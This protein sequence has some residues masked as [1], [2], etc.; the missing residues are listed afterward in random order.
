MTALRLF[1]RFG[2]VPMMIVGLN[3]LAVY[4][5][6][7]GYSFLWICFLFGVAVALSLLTEWILPYEQSWNHAHADSGK[8]VAHGVI[9][10]PWSAVLSSIPVPPGAF[11]VL[12]AAGMTSLLILGISFLAPKGSA[13]ADNAVRPSAS[14]AAVVKMIDFIAFSFMVRVHGETWP[15]ELGCTK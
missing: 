2:Y 4:L 15:L 3:V 6:A 10:E 5:V 13:F 14:T 12:S 1:A 7:S 9:Y 11:P 8:D